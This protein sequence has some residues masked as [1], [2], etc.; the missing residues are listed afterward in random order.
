M[1]FDL[2][3]CIDGI[4]A[5]R[6][7]VS[8]TETPITHQNKYQNKY[9]STVSASVLHRAFYM[10][11]YWSVI[12]GFYTLCSYAHWGNHLAEAYLSIIYYFGCNGVNSN[13]IRCQHYAKLCMKFIS[14]SADT[15]CMYAQHVYGNML[16]NGLGVRK[17]VKLAEIMYGKAAEQGYTQVMRS[18]ADENTAYKKNI[19]SST[20]QALNEWEVRTREIRETLDIAAK[21][22]H[23]CGSS[24]TFNIATKQASDLAVK[25]AWK[26]WDKICVCEP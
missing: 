5:I 6:V 24:N 10:A 16:D 19:K 15:G 23:A 20:T 7:D 21:H 17:N 22:E 2:N 12:E 13:K 9:A 26:S 18:F 14:Q 11:K 8:L 25:Q 3:N 4:D 1:Q